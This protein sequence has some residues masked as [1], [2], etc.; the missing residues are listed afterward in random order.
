MKLKLQLTGKK[1][2][3]LWTASAKFNAQG[4]CKCF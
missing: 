4:F 2:Q 3:E 1:I